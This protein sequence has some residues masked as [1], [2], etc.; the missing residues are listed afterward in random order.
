MNIVQITGEGTHSQLWL[1]FAIAAALMAAT[2]GGWFVWSR[3]LSRIERKL[4]QRAS[5]RVATGKGV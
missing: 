2:F 4:Q 3:L 1:Y 5:M